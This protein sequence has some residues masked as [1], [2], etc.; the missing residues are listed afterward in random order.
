MSAVRAKPNAR[1]DFARSN[2]PRNTSLEVQARPKIALV[3]G[4]GLGAFADE[5]AAPP[6]FLTRKFPASSPQRRDMPD[7]W[8]SAKW[9]KLPSPSCK[10][11][12]ICT[13]DIRRGRSFIPCASCGSLGIRAAI[14]TN[15]AG[16]INLGFKPGSWS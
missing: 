1:G 10:G 7:G 14:L 12:S 2:A 13:R 4:S 16:A 9:V 3:L 15:A 8:C 6:A 11:A 5:L